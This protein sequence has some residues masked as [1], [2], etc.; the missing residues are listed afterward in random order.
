MLFLYEPNE[1]Q[2]GALIVDLDFPLEAFESVDRA[3]R[4]SLRMEWSIFEEVNAVA[5][6][7]WAKEYDRRS[8][9][10]I[11]RAVHGSDASGRGAVPQPRFG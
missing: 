7:R 9:R 6:D 10:L 8:E 1:T 11:D 3:W 4:E 2:F 5:L